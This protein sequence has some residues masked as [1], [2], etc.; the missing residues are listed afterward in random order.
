MRR[1]VTVCGDR[2]NIIIDILVNVPTAL[3]VINTAID[4]VED[5]RNHAHGSEQLPLIV[6][7]NPPRV[8][9]TMR[10]DFEAVFGGV[11]A[12]N[13]AIDILRILGFYR[14]REWISS[15]EYDPFAD[16]FTHLR[17]SKNSMATIEPPIGAPDKTVQNFMAILNAPPR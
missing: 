1:T 4:D 5:M 6:P 15:F 8:T 13:P 7:I 9:K 16:R 17:T 11:I 14:C 12:P 3:T 10:N 2:F